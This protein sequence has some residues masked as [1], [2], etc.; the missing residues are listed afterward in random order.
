MHAARPLVTQRFPLARVDAYVSG[1]LN[2][3]QK[4]MSISINKKK[5]NL[6]DDNVDAG[7]SNE[8]KIGAYPE[9]LL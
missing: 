9:I 3:P 1:K 4:T 5:K 6:F 8:E 2:P 7:Q